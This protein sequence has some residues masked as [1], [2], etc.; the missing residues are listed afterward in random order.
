MEDNPYYD[1]M[2]V[3]DPNMLFGREELLRMLFTS[4]MKRQCFSLEGTRGIGKSSILFHMQSPELQKRLGF[5]T[6]LERYIFVYIDMRDY[7]HHTLDEFFQDLCVQIARH[8]P[9][10]VELKASGN[11]GADRFTKSLQELYQANYHT[12]LLMDAFDKVAEEQQFGP[13]FFSFLRSPATRGWISYITAS[14]KPLYQISPDVASSPFFSGFQTGYVGALELEEARQLISV[15]ASA[16]GLPFSAYEI[17]W[18]LEQA[19]RHPFFLQRVCHH[20]F[21]EK[22]RQQRGQVIDYRKVS[23]DIYEELSRYF[24]SIWKSLA[25]EQQRDLKYE[26]RQLPDSQRKMGELSESALFLHHIRKNFQVEQRSL[27]VKD[28]REAL[29]NLNDRAFLQASVLAEMHAIDVLDSGLDKVVA[30][31]RGLLVQEL[32][33]QAFERMKPSG[34]RSDTA[35]EW[36]LYN[37]LYYHYFKHQITNEQTAARLVISRRQFYRDQERAILALIQELQNLDAEAFSEHP[38]AEVL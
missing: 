24:D 14:I 22:R 20:L 6:D 17:Q 26:M 5:G 11:R 34:V 13:N 32:L 19:G 28:V 10:N 33:R 38:R 31:K 9:Q 21:E 25:S 30:N 23:Q 37:I 7:L 8:V 29:D 4:C 1:F 15:P 16:A 2:A 18:I 27:T 36:R 35:P 3:R 12:V